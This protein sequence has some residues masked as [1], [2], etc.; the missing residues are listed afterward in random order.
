MY[1]LFVPTPKLI[2]GGA[3]LQLLALLRGLDKRRFRAVVAPLYPGGALVDEVR[4]VPGVTVV[5]LHRRS[6]WDFSTLLRV[7]ALLRAWRV[8]IVMPFVSPSAFFGLLPGL[9]VGTPVLVATERSGSRHLFRGGPKLYVTVEDRLARLADVVVANSEAGR[10][11]LV[12]RGVP[13]EQILVIRNGLDPCRLRPAPERVADCR[14]RL[15]VPEG[16]QVVGVLATL[17]PAKGHDTFLKAAALIGARRPATR[18]AIVG[19]GPLRAALEEQARS[20]GLEDRLVFFGH[21]PRVADHLGAID[22]L[23]SSSWDFEGHSN[24]IL[25]AMSL[26]IPVVATDVGGN[27]EL[28]EDGVTGRLVPVRDHAAIAEQVIGLLEDRDAAR[29]LAA[30]ARA[31]VESRFGLER[32]VTSYEA[33]FTR[34]LT[35]GRRRRWSR[36]SQ[37]PCAT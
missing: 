13:D 18:F 22:V 34:L 21:Q 17:T 3:Q 19:D 8:D 25:E 7:A 36:R 24:S 10:R 31:M 27:G 4:A 2:V 29:A 6:K 11:L 5:D 28:V 37:V 12:R 14:A 23:V 15:G 30:N 35:D 32:M 16:G 20:L 26:G 33:L 1:T 9:L